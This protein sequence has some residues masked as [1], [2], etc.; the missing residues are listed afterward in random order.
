[1][2]LFFLI[3]KILY[4]KCLVIIFFSCFISFKIYS[5]SIVLT[6]DST[7]ASYKKGPKQGWG[8]NLSSFLRDEIKIKNLAIGGQSTKSYI[9][10]GHWLKAVKHNADI[11]FIQFGHNDQAKKHTK[12][13]SSYFDNLTKMILDVQAQGKLPVV[14]SSP[15]RLKFEKENQLTQELYAY[16]KSA[17]DI[18][19][20]NN[21]PFIDLYEITEELYSELG[22]K[23]SLAFFP[24][25][26][27]THTNSKGSKLLA[28]RI[29]ESM[30]LIPEL[31]QLVKD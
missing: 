29:A 9:K 2:K 23:K 21:I 24:K 31:S 10:E 15:H 13:T 7:V 26:D 12:A 14:L 19:A 18:A 27:T 16:A 25:G 28:S 3:F 17:K 6:G 22:K 5:Q 8:Q 11:V 30:K 4:L 20:K 1:M